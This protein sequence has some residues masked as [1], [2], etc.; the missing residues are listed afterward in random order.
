MFTSRKWPAPAKLNLFLHVTARRQDGY[1]DLQTLFQ[2]I[3]LH[4]EL[5]FSIRPDG[6]IHCEGGPADIPAEKN[7]V[8]K[9][10]R[11]LKSAAGVSKGVNITLTKNI[12]AGAGLGGGS[13][14][15]A[16]TL[17][18]LNRLWHCNLSL[19]DLAQLGKSLGADVP[20]FVRGE[21]AFATGIGEELDPVT[22]GERHY[23]L[24]LLP[25]HVSTAELF[26]HPGLDRNGPV[27][28]REMALAGK[29]INAFEPVVSQLYPDIGKALDEA[30]KL[31][32][33]RMTG[34]GSSIFIEMPDAEAAMR[35]TLQ[36]NSLYNVRAVRG[37]DYS[38]VHKMLQDMV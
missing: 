24:V 22:L 6:L 29:G 3:D 34:T 12:P 19:S 14:D 9:A 27:I 4:D 23:V 30:S 15:A 17:L 10:A 31:G 2:L 38:P 16:T 26:N 25:V 11:K 13:S 32:Q 36:L 37:E 33:A 5:Q 7:L 18:V 1:H 28:S 21:T 8:V 35:A 20:V